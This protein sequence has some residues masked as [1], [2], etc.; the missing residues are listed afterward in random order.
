MTLFQEPH[1]AFRASVRQFIEE[2]LT[3][4][5]DE[6]ERTEHVPRSVFRDLGDA[7]LLG[8]TQP[9]QH[10]GRALDFGYAVV[11]AEELPRCRMG[12]MTLSILAQTNFF[13]PLT[14]HYASDLEKQTFR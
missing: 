8:L 10:G 11:L 7:N 14:T 2:R 6:W 12:G 4:H 1:D 13:F 5:A 9:A 3:P